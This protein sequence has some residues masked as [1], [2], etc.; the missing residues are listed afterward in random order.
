MS[1]VDRYSKDELGNVYIY[2]IR[3]ITFSR[4]RITVEEYIQIC[5]KEAV[6]CRDGKLK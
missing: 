1:L 2:G 5:Y 4:N 3:V 6:R